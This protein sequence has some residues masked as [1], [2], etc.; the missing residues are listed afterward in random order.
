[1]RPLAPST[2]DSHSWRDRLSLRTQLVAITALLACV[3]G[4]GLVAVV[5]ISLAGAASST[6]KGVLNDRATALVA[7]ITSQSTTNRLRVPRSQLDPGVAVY[8]GRGNKLAGSIPPSMTDEFRDLSRAKHERFLEGG[9]RFVILA[10]PFRTSVGTTGV[11]VVA[12]PIG[13][14]ERNEQSALVVSIVAGALLVTMAAGSAAWIS[15]RVLSPVEQMARTADDWSEHHLEHRFSL[16]P[17]S[18]EIRAL[19]NTLDGLLDKVATAIRAEQRLTSELAHELRTPLTTIRGTADLMLLRSDL[20]EQARADLQ[21]I[22]TTTGSMASTISTLLEVARRETTEFRAGRTNLATLGARLQ[23][24]PLPPGTVHVDLPSDVS[25][26]VPETLALR[27]LSPILTNA[28]EASGNA[29][30]SAEVRERHVA[31]HVADDGPGISAENSEN[32]FEAGWSDNEGS[33]LGLPLARRVARSAG[34]D[35]TLLEGKNSRGGATFVVTFPR[36]RTA[37]TQVLT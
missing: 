21:L 33:G 30:I 8:D 36:A 2:D 31:L 17:P 7:G 3:V 28:F 35:A 34:G 23:Q 25:I 1:M 4:A 29:W 10:R 37:P 19:G 9:E 6:I 13:P 5:Q 14:Y 12:E 18:N 15:K 27:A 32:V 16:G 26:E 24:L 11:A 22:S 20:D